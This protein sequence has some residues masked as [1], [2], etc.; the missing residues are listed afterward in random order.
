M[1]GGKGS[2]GCTTGGAGFSIGA[3]WTTSVTGSGFVAQALRIK[4]AAPAKNNRLIS[5]SFLWRE[6]TAA[7]TEH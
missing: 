7:P 2:A 4:I 6:N 1:M 5:F 3:V